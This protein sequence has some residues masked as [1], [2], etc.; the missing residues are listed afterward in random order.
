MV[1]NIDAYRETIKEKLSTKR[2]SHSVAVSEQAAALARRFGADEQKALAAG[3]L[4]DITKEYTPEQ[5][6]TVFEQ[7]GIELSDVERVAAKLWHAI[8]GAAL[9]HGV[10]RIDD[11]EILSA[12]RYHTTGRAG[13]SLLEKIVYLADFT[14]ADR[15]FDGVEELRGALSISLDSGLSAAYRFSIEELL[16][17][18]AAIHPDTVAA[19]N[20]LVLG[21]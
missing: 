15:D 4:H 9:L 11:P 2:Y 19:R 20:A 18:G 7:Y 1:L 10:M 14:S 3:L 21:K 16:D 8:S 6:L 12:V 17:K 5:H 13:M